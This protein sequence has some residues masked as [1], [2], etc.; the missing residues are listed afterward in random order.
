MPTNVCLW[1]NP[2][3][4]GSRLGD[5]GLGD[6]TMTMTKYAKW[7]DTFGN[8]VLVLLLSAMPVAAIGF[9]AQSF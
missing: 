3:L 8:S 7:V 4:Q 5:D 9:V 6:K 1:G 2:D